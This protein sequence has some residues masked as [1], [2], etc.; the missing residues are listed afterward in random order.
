MSNAG[1]MSTITRY[2]D[3][4]A[5]NATFIENSYES[6]ATSTVGAGGAASVTFS[7]IP[8][9]YQHL[10]IRF[11]ARGTYA[12]GN[13][14]IVGMQFN[15]DTANNYAWHWLFGDGSSAGA[16]AVSTTSNITFRDINSAN[17]TAN[18]FGAFIV[19]ILDYSNTSKY[20]TSRALGGYDANGNGKINVDS[21]LW[22]ST[23]VVSNI[24]LNA[25]NANFAQ[26][27]S[28]ALYGIRG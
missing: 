27:S 25:G 19:D 12:T 18:T 4:L 15:S 11:T 16:G 13:I 3:M 5:G 10:Q 17:T 7:S 20:K 22:M 14:E 28:F 8:S 1:G 24:T 9:I 6:I 2:T 23:S 26:Y 21:G